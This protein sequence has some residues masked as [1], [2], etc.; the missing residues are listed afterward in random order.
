MFSN[1]RKTIGVVL[2]R[3][4]GEFQNRLC[5]G[6]LSKAEELG[7]NVAVFSSYG[8]YGQNNRYFAGDQHLWELPPYEDLDGIIL[9]LDTMDEKASR[10]NVLRHVQDRCSCPIVSI[11][12]M[13]ECANNLLVDNTT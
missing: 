11:R 10:E 5:R 7:Y 12:E 6:I 4:L 2:E 13:L 8:N 3:A 1:N 9:A